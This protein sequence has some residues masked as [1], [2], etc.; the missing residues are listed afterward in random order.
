MSFHAEPQ[1]WCLA[2]AVTQTCPQ[3]CVCVCIKRVVG[4][5]IQPSNSG[6]LHGCEEETKVVLGQNCGNGFDENKT[7]LKIS[8]SD[9]RYT[10][11]TGTVRT[12]LFSDPF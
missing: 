12:A 5:C 4:L 8:V 2:W 6:I 3:L 11:D 7:E 1:G 9:G 10:P